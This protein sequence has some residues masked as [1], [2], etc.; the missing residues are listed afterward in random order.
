MNKG[1]DAPAAGGDELMR[2][3]YVLPVLAV[4]VVTALSSI[5]IV[6]ERKMA[7][8]CSSAR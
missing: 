5:F 7:W 3:A 8:C 6:D 4:V 1:K 2:I